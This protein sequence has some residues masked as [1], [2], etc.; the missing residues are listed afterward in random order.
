MDESER[1]EESLL[2][3]VALRNAGSIL[4]ARQRAEQ[5]LVLAKQALE[6]KTEE[7][8]RTLAQMRETELKFRVLAQA[9]PNHVW[10]ATPDG[11]LDWFNDK[12]LQYSGMTAAAL[13]ESGWRGIVHPDDSRPARRAWAESLKSGRPYETEFR[14]HRHD[15]V[16]RWHLIR[17]VPA[18]M[19][20]GVVRWIGT[21]TDIEEQKAAQ[22]ALAAL[23]ASL[24]QRV[25]ERATAL[26]EAEDRL[27][28]GQKMEAIGQLTGG[29]AHDFNNLLQGI[30]GSLELVRKRIGQGRIAELDRFVASALAAAQRAAAL[31]HRLLAFS[32]RQPLDPRA[33]QV[34]PLL[35]SIADLLRRTL[36]EDIG[37]EMALADDLWLTLCDANQ[38]ESAVLN[39]AIN[40]RDA[41]EHGG[42]LTIE[43]CNVRIDDARAAHDPD[44][45]PGEYVCI[46]V[47]DTGPGMPGPVLARAF[48]PFFTTKPIGKGTGLGLSMIYGFTR[49]SG[50]N[51]RIYSEPG[52]GATV[53]LY[54]PRHRVGAGSEAL[55][56]ADAQDAPDAP[57]QRREATPGEVVLV[58]EDEVLVRGLVVDLLEGLGY[59]VLEAAHGAAAVEIA[60]AA[61]RLDLLVTDVGLPGMNGR[62]LA[63]FVR[64]RHAEVKVLFMTGYAESAATAQGFLAPGMAL[65]TK[66]FAL[67]ALAG[68]VR[69]TL[70][71]PLRP[72]R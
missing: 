12:V 35:A 14:I 19:E 18:E 11:R 59:R 15:G 48:E 54:L 62:Q 60:Q 68:R 43:T 32:R 34:N 10:T 69:A 57:S 8:G 66:P 46:A 38:L 7:L 61:E 58:V 13:T 45:V 4:A 2:R 30:S 31:T 26:K 24:E 6:L 20:G 27:R 9:M 63:D 53:K 64:G 3:T 33:L 51:C 44:L 29:I 28:Q 39:L 72:G 49:Q 55:T 23:N 5:E 47:S 40:A 70:D 22:A 16:Y 37:L 56:V 65:I 1:G 42:T 25:A 52:L 50:G 71:A 21:N 41:M 67:D 17:A 36:G